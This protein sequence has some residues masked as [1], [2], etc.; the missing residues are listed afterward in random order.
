SLM[1][2]FQWMNIAYRYI[3]RWMSMD[4]DQ[5]MDFTLWQVGLAYVFILILFIIV[6]I[7]KIAREKLIIIST[8]RMTFQLIIVGY[9]LIYVLDNPNPFV[10]VGIILIMLT[11]AVFNVYQRT[12]PH[13][14]LSLKKMI[15]LA[16]F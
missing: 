10:T 4:N 6:R 7:K 13:I 3:R 5:V 11:F 8:L 12:K 14:K 9:I 15:A 2:P 16:M 1:R